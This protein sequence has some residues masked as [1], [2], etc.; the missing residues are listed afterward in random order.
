MVND[1]YGMADDI[2]IK[3]LKQF[4]LIVNE[5]KSWYN[6][7]HAGNLSGSIENV[8]NNSGKRK[9]VPTTSDKYISN[10]KRVFNYHHR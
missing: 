10:V 3:G 7:K 6:Q 5:Y 1:A 2:G 8:S 4:E 9:H